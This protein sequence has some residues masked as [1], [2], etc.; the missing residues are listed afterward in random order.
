MLSAS[1]S[2]KKQPPARAGQSLVEYA[3]VLAL[4]AMLAV[5]VLTGVGRRARNQYTRVGHAFEDRAVAAATGGVEKPQPPDNR[6][7]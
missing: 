5:A 1:L 7:K 6:S 2:R 4:I 3:V